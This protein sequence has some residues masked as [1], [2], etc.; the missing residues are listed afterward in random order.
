MISH[1]HQKKYHQV[2]QKQIKDTLRLLDNGKVNNVDD[3]LS[4]TAETSFIG[5]LYEFNEDV[6]LLIAMDHKTISSIINKKVDDFSFS[7]HLHG[8]TKKLAD[9]TMDEIRR[10]FSTGMSFEDMA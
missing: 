9:V 7:E 4:K 1:V 5:T 10:G 6:P 2:L 8:D 3:F